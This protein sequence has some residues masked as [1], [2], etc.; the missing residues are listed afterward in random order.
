MRNQRRSINFAFFNQVQNLRTV[1]AIHATGFENKIFAVHIGQRQALRFIVERHN[2]YDSVRTRAFPRELEGVATAGNLQNNVR[3]AMV[4]M[5]LNKGLAFL[6]LAK[7]YIGIMLSDKLRS[8]C[9]FFADDDALRLL[10]HNTQQGADT[11]RSRTDN[12]H[13]ILLGDFRNAC[14]P[15]AGSKNITYKKCLLIGN[16]VGN[17]VQPWS[18]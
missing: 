18:A 7:Q 4:G 11:R 6:R 16:A 9:I 13:R 5:L 1:A 8:G 10:Q 17:F 12:Q 3:T 2:R 15:K 14:C